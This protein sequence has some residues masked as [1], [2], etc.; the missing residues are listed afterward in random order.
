MCFNLDFNIYTCNF[1]QISE[2]YIHTAERSE[3]IACI[4]EWQNYSIFTLIWCDYKVFL[5]VGLRSNAETFDV[6]K[7]VMR[8]GKDPNI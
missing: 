2:V 5:N 6:H 1:F 3:S 7:N 8:K 4:E